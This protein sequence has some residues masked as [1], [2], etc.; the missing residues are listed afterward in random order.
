[1]KISKYIDRAKIQINMMLNK[2][3]YEIKLNGKNESF[4]LVFNQLIKE[5]N[6]NLIFDIG[7]NQG[8]FIDYIIKSGYKNKI[9]AFEPLSQA[10]K[11]LLEKYQ[12]YPNIFLE[13]YAVGN[14]NRKNIE[15]NIS[16]NLVSSSILDICQS[17]INS[18]PE[19]IFTG[20]QET[21]LI[22]LD[23]YARK[24]NVILEKNNTLI[25]IDTQGFEYEVLLGSLDIL[26]YISLINIELSLIRLYEN[27]KLMH[28]IMN[29]L[30]ENDFVMYHFSPVFRNLLNGQLLQVDGLFVNAKQF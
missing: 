22:T 23:D 17:H 9:I 18:D 1:M 30:Y 4:N 27:Q 21:E 2:F 19:S 13:N 7:A 14:E 16:K 5:K 10:Y 28:E 24:N 20:S 11:S 26:K 15:I 8:S 6:I 12:A 3:G 29:I 25:K